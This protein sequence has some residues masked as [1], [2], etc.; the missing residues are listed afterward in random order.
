MFFGSC[1]C[2]LVIQMFGYQNGNRSQWTQIVIVLLNFGYTYSKFNLIL[3]SEI[4]YYL[5][6]ALFKKMFSY[7]K[8]V[9]STWAVSPVHRP[10]FNIES[11][12][13]GILELRKML[14]LGTKG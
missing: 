2:Y 1:Y 6:C 13:V 4:I 3:R 11:D 5:V 12:R 14:I 7:G 9:E 8:T 10:Q